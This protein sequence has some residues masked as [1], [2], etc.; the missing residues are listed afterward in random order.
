L[1]RDAPDSFGGTVIG[2]SLLD[3][4]ATGVSGERKVLL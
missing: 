2:R 4:P 3:S 1:L